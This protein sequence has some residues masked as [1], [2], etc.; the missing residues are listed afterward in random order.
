MDLATALNKRA[1]GHT[2][3]NERGETATKSRTTRRLEC[4]RERSPRP[5]WMHVAAGQ[6]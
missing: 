5:D 1:P 6:L 4:E 2:Y 3:T